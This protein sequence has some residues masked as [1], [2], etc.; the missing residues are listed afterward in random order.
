VQRVK[1]FYE[2]FAHSNNLE[3][4]DDELLRMLE[5]RH[6]VFVFEVTDTTDALVTSNNEPLR[7]GDFCAA[8]FIAEHLSEYNGLV[9]GWREAGGSR[10]V[11]GG[12]QLQRLMHYARSVHDY[13][14]DPA[15][16]GYFAVAK[17]TPEA[18]R[19]NANIRAV[20]FEPWDPNQKLAEHKRAHQKDDD[21]RAFYLLP[22]DAL[23]A[24]AQALLDLDVNPFLTRPDRKR[25]GEHE[26]VAVEMDLAI[27][28]HH[29]P[30]VELLADAQFS[31]IF[32]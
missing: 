7:V 25:S 5:Y 30:A 2:R 18:E 3:R 26:V 22:R 28:R 6:N 24:H 11:L 21:P 14:L 32:K 15:R 27:L 1:G 4:G 17:D 8:S 29:R 19:T 31:E 20:G 12:F 13:L 10:V 16:E 9:P 23:P